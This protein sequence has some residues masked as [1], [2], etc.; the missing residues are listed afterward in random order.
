[1]SALKLKLVETCEEKLPSFTDL[2]CGYFEKCS[3]AKG[4][5]EDNQDL[6]ALCT[7][8]LGIMTKSH[9]GATSSWGGN[10]TKFNFN[11]LPSCSKQIA[12]QWER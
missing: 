10:I 7:D 6:Q 4:W 12:S 2:E 1:V 8:T 9:C 11:A 5:I 3:N